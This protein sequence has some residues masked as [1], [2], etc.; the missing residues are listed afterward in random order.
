MDTV[1]LTYDKLSVEEATAAVTSP[2]CGAVSLFV[3]TTR[4]NFDEKK[5]V[6]L[7]YEAYDSMAVKVMKELCAEVRRK[8][9]VENIAI[10]HRLGTVPVCE[11]SV[12]IAISSE[13]RTESLEAVQYT[14]NTLK[15]QVPIW[16]KEVYDDQSC[17][18]PEW[19]A[20][21]ESPKTQ[22]KIEQSSDVPEDLIQI[23][24]KPEEVRR[25]IDA[26]IRKKREDIDRVNIRDFCSN[27][28]IANEESGDLLEMDNSCARVNAV[29]VS[30]KEGRSHLKISRVTNEWGPQTRGPEP[31][32]VQAESTSLTPVQNNIPPRVGERLRNIEKHLNLENSEKPVSK[33]IYS[34]LKKI[35]D[36]IL[37]LEGVSP[38][39]FVQLSQ[40]QPKSLEAPP[41]K[42]KRTYTAQELRERLQA[43]QEFQ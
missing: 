33:D 7:D 35:E 6:Q 2:K 11:A 13:H 40:N 16:K 1:K 36:R 39:Y 38:E 28:R 25:R 32:L 19:K 9:A 10:Y 17:S 31:A 23:T 8:W 42:K 30:R 29:L 21:K 20:N 14:I 22:R 12:V 18:K 27:P 43:I 24:A 34:R 41:E 26:L 15:G 5:V 3:G 37:F 4:D